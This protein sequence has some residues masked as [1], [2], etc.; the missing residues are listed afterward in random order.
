MQ[1]NTARYAL[2]LPLLTVAVIAVNAMAVAQVSEA[3]AEAGIV[4]CTP[5]VLDEHNPGLA[6]KLDHLVCFQGYISNFNTTERHRKPK[7]LG[8]PHWVSHHIKRAPDSP[9]SGNRPTKWFSIPE[10][11]ARK[12]AP[13]DDS[14]AFSKRFR[15]THKNWF[16]RGHLA[17]KYLTE[18]L[19][20]EPAFFTHNVANAVPQRSQFNKGPWLTLECMTGAW[21]NKYG[22]VW[23]VAGPVFKRN[24]TISWLRS[25]AHKKAMPVAIPFGIFKVIARKDDDGWHLLSF[26]YPQTNRTYRKGPFDPEVFFKSV[27]DIEQ[28]TGERFLSGIPDGNQ[29]KQVTPE[30]L[31]PVSKS[32]FDSGCDKQKVDVR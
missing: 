6:D 11:A 25:D 17:Q 12:I 5:S 21:A 3:D 28:I 26:V 32:D 20:N 7:Y 15:K 14:Y 1:V 13:T 24:R 30:K 29:L 2:A 10:L 9:E 27:A 19:G 23:V 31:W 8:V 22:E 16:E 18:R 4:D